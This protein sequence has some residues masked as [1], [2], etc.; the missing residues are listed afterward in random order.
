[1]EA[2]WKYPQVRQFHVAPA[3]STFA[4]LAVFDTA[5]AQ[6][7]GPPKSLED[8]VEKSQLENY[9]NVRAQFEA[10]N[11]HMGAANPSTG[12][13]YWMLNNAWPSLTWQLYDYFLNPAGAYFGARIAN[14]PLHIQYSYDTRAV[15]LVNQ[16][17]KGERG[18]QARIRVRNLDGG[19][20]F[21]R[22][23]Q[24]IDLASGTRELMR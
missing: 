15:V 14:E 21:E 19:V 18:L 23:L 16:T 17:L 10:F 8:Y 5:L 11:A 24:G 13:I 1:L 7:Y 6:R 12:V 9:D 2:L 3:W 22:R 20:A 4:K